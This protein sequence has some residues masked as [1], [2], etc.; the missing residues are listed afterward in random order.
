M[1]KIDLDQIEIEFPEKPTKIWG[2]DSDQTFYDF[3]GLARIGSEEVGHI[4]LSVCKKYPL[5]KRNDF[6][7]IEEEGYGPVRPVVVY[8]GTE[9]EYRGQGANGKF[10]ILTNE[11]IKRR[12]GRSLAS[13]THFCL[14]PLGKQALPKYSQYPGR[15]VWEKLEAQGLAYSK[16]YIGKPRWIMR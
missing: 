4:T 11:I 12:F 13:D 6:W 16:P 8:Q 1:E 15:R 10:I 7:F 14:S 2:L 3:R 9:K 5:K